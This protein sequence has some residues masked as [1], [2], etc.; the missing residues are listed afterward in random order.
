MT[1]A[2]MGLVIAI[3]FN[4]VL[5]NVLKGSYMSFL[6]LRGAPPPTKDRVVI[7]V[8]NVNDTHWLGSY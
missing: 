6:P 3:A 5:V 2:D 7:D 1:L 4:V 8:T